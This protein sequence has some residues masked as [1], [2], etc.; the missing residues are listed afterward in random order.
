L[1]AWPRKGGPM[2]I[3]LVVFDMAGTTVND[4][5]SV[6]R[7]LRASLEAA[8]LRVTSAQVNAVMGLP[9]P[10]AIA[11]LIDGSALK[12]ELGDQ[13]ETVH[14]D[15]VARSIEFY[16]RDPSVYEVP[17]TTRVFETL[18]RSGIRVALDTGFNRAIA[19]VILDRLG[20][21]QSPLIDATICS[22]EVT[23]GRP[24]PDMIQALM[25]RLA[26]GD[27]RRVAKVGDTPAD[28]QEGE[29]AGCGLVVGVTGGTHSRTELLAYYH[30]DLIETIADLPDLLGLEA[31]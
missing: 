30:T 2:K 22:D 4:D 14:N 17:G 6:N 31:A 13:V 19:Q 15:F 27:V 24:Y 23:R 21:S 1:I 25:A 3:D 12:D 10:S 9:K 28:L 7:C 5:D 11:I 26:V 16:R 29:R 18:K 20:W 8:G